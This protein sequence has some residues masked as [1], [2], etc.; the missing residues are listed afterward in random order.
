[1]FQDLG[2]NMTSTEAQNAPNLAFY[3][4]PVLGNTWFSMMTPGKGEVKEGTPILPYVSA[5]SI[6][7]FSQ[8]MNPMSAP[9]SIYGGQTSGQAVLSGQLTSRD[10]MGI[11]RYQLGFQS[12][13]G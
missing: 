2:E 11:S 5:E 9:Y 7:Y 12:S 8:M 4:N 6:L 1:M 13:T 10:S 3:S